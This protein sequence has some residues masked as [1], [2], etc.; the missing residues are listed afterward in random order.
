MNGL[1]IVGGGFA[2]VWA[3]VTA[4][5]E[6][7][8]ADG[9]FPIRVVSPDGHIVMRPRLYEA[10]P[11]DY[12]LPLAPTLAPVDIGIVQGAATAIDT[13]AGTIDIIGETG[14]ATLAWDALV[15]AAGSVLNPP[16]APGLAAHGFDIDSWAGA[17]KLDRR[18]A[19]LAGDDAPGAS[20]VAIVGGGFTGIELALEMRDR[21]AAHGADGEAATILLVEKAGEIGPELG[22]GPRR[23]ILAALA[24]ARI[25]IRLGSAVEQVTAESVTLT[26]GET[27]PCRTVVNTTGMRASPLA[28]SLGVPLD[29]IGR[30]PTDEMLRVDGRPAVFAAGDIAHARVDDAGHVA[31]MSCQHAM[32]MGKAAGY[33]AARSLLGLDLRPYRQERYVTCLDLGRR[34]AV[35]TAGWDR[36]V[37]ATGATAKAR[38]QV[39]NGEI[40]YPPTGSRDDILAAGDIDRLPGRLS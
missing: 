38:K 13:D 24:D 22:P 29:G 14:D 10:R 37:Q 34:G 36:E 26:G 27:L 33:N 12:R 25:D 9:D 1:V 19:D 21:L 31:L 3:A 20:T 8:A 2:G 6:R 17:M 39:I 16:A 35:L 11:E 7:A 28:Q 30:L 23:E 15:L 4:A 18:L 40:I 5:H 32:P